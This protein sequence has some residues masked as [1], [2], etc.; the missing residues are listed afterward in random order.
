MYLYMT[1]IQCDMRLNDNAWTNLPSKY[2][3]PDVGRLSLGTA[4]RTPLRCIHLSL[5]ILQG[6]SMKN[7][8]D[9]HGLTL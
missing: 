2:Q 1:Y 8:H 3:W 4:S 5:I 6:Q 9:F 7:Y